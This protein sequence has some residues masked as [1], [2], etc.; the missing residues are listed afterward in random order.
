MN[1]PVINSVTL[2]LKILNLNMLQPKNV[3]Q[4]VVSL[5]WHLIFSTLI[6]TSQ[7][8]DLALK[9]NIEKFFA[10]GYVL[11]QVVT[12]NL[13]VL[14]IIFNMEAWQ[15]LLKSLAKPEF[16]SAKKLKYIQQANNVGKKNFALYAIF[17]VGGVINYGLYC[18]T[19]NKNQALGMYIPNFLQCKLIYVLCSWLELLGKYWLKLK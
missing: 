3:K 1:S 15:K 6:L 14:P 18:N 9:F 2:Y 8:I 4:Q 11:L 17:V 16:N 19:L 7:L 10:N 13:K 12:F 5:V